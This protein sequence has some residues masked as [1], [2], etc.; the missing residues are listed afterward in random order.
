ME[1]TEKNK[2]EVVKKDGK[3]P[4][5]NE[6]KIVKRDGKIMWYVWCTKCHKKID[7]GVIPEE[8]EITGKRHTLTNGHTTII[9]CMVVLMRK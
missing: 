5:E 7:E 8:I 3:I 1:T 9:G 6:A 2:A 4:K